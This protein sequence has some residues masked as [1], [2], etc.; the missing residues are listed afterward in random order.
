[1]IAIV[2]G[3]GR[4]GSHSVARF[5]SQ[6]RHA[7]G[8][9]V[10]V[11]HE[12][13]W[14]EIVTDLL[15]RREDRVNARLRGFAHDVEVSPFLLLMSGPPDCAAQPGVPLIGVVR[16]GRATVRSGMSHGWYWNPQAHML[17]WPVLL[18]RFDGDRFEQCCQYW[19]WTCGR[20]LE[21]QATVVTLER[22]A[23]D[24]RERLRLL[25]RLQIVGAGEDFPRENQTCYEAPDRIEHMT[26]L[27]NQSDWPGPFPPAREWSAAQRAAFG[28]YCGDYMDQ[29]YPAWEERADDPAA[30]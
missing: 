29:F 8:R 10:T 14:H 9:P 26:V 30:P 23:G 20:L 15:D 16:D 6:Q 17:G 18:P 24:P 22:L 19:S 27:A 7:D 3:S 13:E 21:W 1:M 11:Q 12:T 4:C 25:G 5:L 2:T 28:R